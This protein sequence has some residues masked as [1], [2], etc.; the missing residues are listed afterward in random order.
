M[1]NIQIKETVTEL[2]EMEALLEEVKAEV[3]SLR[4]I[5]KEEMTERKTETIET[6]DF[7]IRWTSVLSNRLD[8][9]AL[10]ETL[11]A[12]YAN[13]TKQIPS[14]KFSISR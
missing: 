2:I 3:E 4:D 8:T 13:F 11:P 9:K 7:I 10:K 14:R 1:T 12:V 5:L 6:P